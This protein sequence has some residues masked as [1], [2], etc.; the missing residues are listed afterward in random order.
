MEFGH[1][2]EVEERTRLQ[3]LFSRQE[4]LVL[5]EK[6][7]SIVLSLVSKDSCLNCGASQVQDFAQSIKSAA[8]KSSIHVR[9][10]RRPEDVSDSVA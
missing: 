3:L 10:A 8:P 2:F 5:C 6:L 7:S 9:G 1:K 4:G